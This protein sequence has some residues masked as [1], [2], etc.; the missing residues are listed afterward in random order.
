[1]VN[2]IN[3]QGLLPKSYTAQLNSLPDYTVHKT[4]DYNVSVTILFQF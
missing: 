2:V 3:K 4:S 1:M